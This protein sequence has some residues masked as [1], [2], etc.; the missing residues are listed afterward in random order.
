MGVSL[1][2]RF[3]LFLVCFALSGPAFAD[4]S[5]G[6]TAFERICAECHGPHGEGGQGGEGPDAPPLVPPPHGAQEILGIA[7]TGRGN[8]PPVPRSAITD[9]EILAV[10]DYLQT[11]SGAKK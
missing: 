4:A 6:K 2:Y 9:A 5:S 8:M 7:R 3:S 10:V 11:L 1:H